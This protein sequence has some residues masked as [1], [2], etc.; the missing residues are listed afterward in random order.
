MHYQNEI[1]T[2][3]QTLKC[4]FVVGLFIL[5]FF[6]VNQTNVVQFFQTHHVKVPS[7]KATFTHWHITPNTTSI[8]DSTTQKK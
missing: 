2:M 5:V 4:F 7:Y 3:A 1:L 6:L 8:S